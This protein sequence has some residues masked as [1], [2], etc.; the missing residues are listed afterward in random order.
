P[1]EAIEVVVHPQSIIHA[2][3][4]F[5]DGSVIAQLGFPSMEL[6]IL[7]A[8]THPDRLPDE[9]VRR[10]DPVAAG[11]L[12]FEPVRADVFRAFGA[13][14]EAARAG[15]TAPAVFNAANEEAVAGFLAGRI[16]FGRIM[17]TIDRVLT[18]HDVRPVSGLEDVVAADAWA[19]TSARKVLS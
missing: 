3:T 2:F 7:Y 18:E 1:Y 15:G 8:L 10:F 11:S 19:R 4:E 13:G 17:E 16:P 12:T 14:L 9:G 6:P 5:C